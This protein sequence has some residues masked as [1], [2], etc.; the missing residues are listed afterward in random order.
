MIHK[1]VHTFSSM[2]QK[3]RPIPHIGNKEFGQREIVCE[4]E[5]LKC[6]ATLI[7]RSPHSYLCSKQHIIIHCLDIVI[8]IYVL[9]NI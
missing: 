4:R 5:K 9:S 7:M 8:Y 6:C 1:Y 2:N 3:R